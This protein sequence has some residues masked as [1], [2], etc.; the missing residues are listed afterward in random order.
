MA[1]SAAGSAWTRTPIILAFVAAN[2]A[3]ASAQMSFGPFVRSDI[4]TVAASC[5]QA[6]TCEDAV[7]MWCGGYT[8]ADRDK[9]G[10]PCENVCHSLEEAQEIK[11][12]IGC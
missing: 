6:A 11:D 5:K 2:A 9:D 3:S 12:A 10:I 7:R 4:V 1:G 8:R